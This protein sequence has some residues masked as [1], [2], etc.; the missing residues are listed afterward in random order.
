MLLMALHETIT[1][2][3]CN[4]E[5]SMN[6][7]VSSTISKTTFLLAISFRYK[8]HLMDTLNP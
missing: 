4:P 6:D 3:Y 5:V 7:K 1:M 8:Q 2:D